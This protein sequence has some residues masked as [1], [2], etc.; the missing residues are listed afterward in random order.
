VREADLRNHLINEA[1]VDDRIVED[2]A[3][4]DPRFAA[5]PEELKKRGITDF[6]LDYAVKLLERLAPKP[7]PAPRTAGAPTPPNTAL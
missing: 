4:P 2:D 1:K 7:G 3:K 6:Q 5:T